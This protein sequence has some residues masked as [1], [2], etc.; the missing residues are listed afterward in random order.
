MKPKVDVV[1]ETSRAQNAYCI[2]DSLCTPVED[3]IALLLEAGVIRE[4]SIPG[5]K[6]SNSQRQSS[7]CLNQNARKM[8]LSSIDMSKSLFQ[9]ELEE[10]SKKYTAFQTHH[11][12]Y[13]FNHCPMGLQTS[14]A[15]MERLI[16]RA[17]YSTGNF[18]A[19]LLDDI[20]ISSDDWQEHLSEKCSRY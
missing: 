15:T 9:I 16:R 5:S 4:S 2:A 7:C 10:N 20:I 6:T 14:T 1:D 3:E 12:A 13:E 18:T 8:Y 17:L 19:S 11:G